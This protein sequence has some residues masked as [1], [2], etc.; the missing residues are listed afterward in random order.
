VE[1]NSDADNAYD[2]AFDFAATIGWGYWRLRT[3]YIS[4]DSFNQDVFID[5]IDN[6]FTV[7][8]DPNSKLPDGSDAE[9]GLITDLMRKEAFQE[10][11]IRTRRT[12]DSDRGDGRHGRELAHRARH[13]ARR[14][15]LRRAQKAKLVMLTDGTVLWADQLPLISRLMAVAGNWREG[16]PGQLQA[17]GEVVQA[18]R[19]GDPGG[20]DAAG[21]LD[22]DRAGVLDERRHRRA[23]ALRQGL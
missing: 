4:E 1:V 20:K 18:D 22:S 16:R 9:K 7:Y 5:V 3:D 21:P 15:F 6:P 23:S 10:G 2:T 17:R 8:F 13:P 12:Q 19:D 14:V 11:S